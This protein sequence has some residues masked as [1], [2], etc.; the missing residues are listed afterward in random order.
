MK[1][2]ISIFILILVFSVFAEKKIK[3]TKVNETTTQQRMKKWDKIPLPPIDSTLIVDIHEFK[4]AVING[5]QEHFTGHDIDLWDRL[6][7][8]LNLKFRY[9]F[10]DSFS[11]VMP[12]IYQEKAHVSIGG[13]SRTADRERGADF[14]P[15]MRSGAGI[16]VSKDIGFWINLWLNIKFYA[17]LFVSIVPFILVWIVYV[18]IAALFMFFLEK[19]NPDFND[20]FG[21]GFPDA[22]FFVH[23]VISST[24]FGNQIP[25]SAW[26]RRVT[27]LLMYSGIGF[28]FPMI[29]GKISSEMSAKN[30]SYITCKEDLRG[31]RVAL[32]EGTVTAKSRTLHDIGVEPTYV[33]TVSQGIDLL[34]GKH[35]DAVVH[36]K[37]ALEFESKDDPALHVVDDLFDIQIYGIALQSNSP[38]RERIC[39]KILEY[40]EDG[41]LDELSVKW[42]GSPRD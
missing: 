23:V 24:G 36:D 9:N 28:M 3:K 5:N 37:P 17:G 32:K 19:G 2:F 18:C 38:L 21:P 7:L 14:V 12:R 11:N 31:K 26:G 4:P 40:E 29:T 27:V 6:A 10:I 22:R 34:K 30:L 8:D 1:R 13:I 35:V 39:Q 20:K 15:Y 41:V 33:K 42:L 25:R 16:M